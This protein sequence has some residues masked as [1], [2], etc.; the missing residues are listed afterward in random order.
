MPRLPG[1]PHELGYSVVSI[2]TAEG[3]LHNPA[4]L[5]IPRLLAM[6]SRLG[7]GLVKEFPELAIPA[8]TELFVDAE[9]A[10]PAPPACRMSY[11]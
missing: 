5:D 2:S 4:G 11:R 1:F 9:I 10:I 8:G 6:R 3:A 7:D